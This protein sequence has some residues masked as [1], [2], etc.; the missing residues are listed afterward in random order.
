LSTPCQRGASVPSLSPHH[1][2]PLPRPLTCPIS[3]SS[4]PP[5]KGVLRAPKACR[6]RWLTPVIL[7][8]WEAEAGGSLEVRNQEFKTSLGNIGRSYL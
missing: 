4:L 5:N 7:G 3:P 8:L 1:Y 2:S 6:A